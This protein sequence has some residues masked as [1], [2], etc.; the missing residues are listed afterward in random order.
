M[1]NRLEKIRALMADE[2][3]VKELFSKE[4]IEDAHDY[5]EVHGV[6]MTLKDL[7]RIAEASRSG[8]PDDPEDE[9]LALIS[10]AAPPLHLTAK[11]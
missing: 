3:F 1:G 8:G 10:G 9:E 7:A 5:F 4:N 2:A 6:E 11:W